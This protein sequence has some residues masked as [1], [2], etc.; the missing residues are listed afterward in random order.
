MLSYNKVMLKVRDHLTMTFVINFQHNHPIKI[1][2]EPSIASLNDFLALKMF[3]CAYSD[4]PFSEIKEQI[5]H[6]MWEFYKSYEIFS[7]II[8]L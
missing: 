1:Q 8:D 7:G 5:K 3:K 4:K 6:M 2:L